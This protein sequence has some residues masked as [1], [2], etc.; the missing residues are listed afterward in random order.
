L[1][2]F[3]VVFAIVVALGALFS[4]MSLNDLK[5]KFAGLGVLA[6]KSKDEIISAVGPPNSVS[7]VGEGKV[8]LQ[9]Q[10]ISEAGGYH[11]ALL[12]DEVGI[13]EGITHEHA[14]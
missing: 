14:S 1:E 2:W 6:G 13:C 9:W 4:W 12:F 8:L 5:S 3:F 11:I 7:D 10:N